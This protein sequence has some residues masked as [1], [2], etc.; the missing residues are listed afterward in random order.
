MYGTHGYWCNT[1][2]FPT[3]CQSCGRSVFFFQCDHGSKVFFDQ[4]GEDWPVHDCDRRA[5]RREPDP[6]RY[7][8]VVIISL[9]DALTGATADAGFFI[10]G[11]RRYVSVC[12]PPGVDNGSTFYKTT[13]WC[14]ELTIIVGVSSHPRFKRKGSDLFMD[15]QLPRDSKAGDK[16]Q[17]RT[18]DGQKLTVN[19]PDKTRNGDNIRLSGHGMPKLDSPHEKGDLFL[20]IRKRGRFGWLRDIFR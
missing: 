18:L 2:T 4:L 20:V 16:I 6:D 5:H 17:V 10:S 9:E 1:R 3:K 13:D 12:L 19:V 8:S 14:P 7:K 11:E 15:I